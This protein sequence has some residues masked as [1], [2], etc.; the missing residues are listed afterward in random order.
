MALIKCPECDKEVSESA[1]SCPNCGYR[2]RKSVLKQK[3]T[4]NNKWIIFAVIAL[5]ILVIGI[6]MFNILRRPDIPDNMSKKSY[7]LGV[8][9]VEQVD[10]YLDGKITYSKCYEKLDELYIEAKKIA[11]NS[12]MWKD[13]SV[14]IRILL[15]Q[16][17]VLIGKRD[18]L[19]EGRN[20]L[21]ELLNIK[22]Y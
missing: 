22:S 21:A 17:G 4:S 14:A 19:V 3:S 6:G 16:G 9:A 8:K 15:V 10:A 1:K 12:T 18:K 7:K 13:D 11:K 5:C 20:F 2:L